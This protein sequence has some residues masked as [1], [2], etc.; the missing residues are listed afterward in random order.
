MNV[1]IS[2]N[3]NYINAH[4]K[5]QQ[6][7]DELGLT[8]LYEE[9]E[10]PM[11]KLERI[12]DAIEN[13]T[14]LTFCQYITKSKETTHYYARLVFTHYCMKFECTSLPGL[15]KLLNRDKSTVIRC[16]KKFEDEVNFNRDFREIVKKVDLLL[17]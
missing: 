12:K 8:V 9:P 14:G 6:F 16:L 15:K 7:A 5:V 10:S 4:K 2:G 3:V 11:M 17:S 1:Y 13:V